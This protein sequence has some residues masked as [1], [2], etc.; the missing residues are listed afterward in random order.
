MAILG[1]ITVSGNV[2]RRKVSFDSADI[3][4]GHTTRIDIVAAPGAGKF[5]RLFG[6]WD[7]FLTADT[8]GYDNVS[9][10][11]RLVGA[12]GLQSGMSAS[13]NG[14][15]NKWKWI[16]TTGTTDSVVENVALEW[17]LSAAANGTGDG[18][19]DLYIS[20]EVITI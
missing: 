5:I 8:T 7:S 12:T 15:A 13:I 2:F 10:Q 3:A 18:A 20:W 9:I 16:V 14:T 6:R 4:A 11:M 19:L 17:D 1:P